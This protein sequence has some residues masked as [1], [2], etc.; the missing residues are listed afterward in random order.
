MAQHLKRGGLGRL[1]REPLV[2]FLVLGAGLFVLYTLINPGAAARRTTQIEVGPD[3]LAWITTTWF[4]QYRRPPSDAELRRLVDDYVHDEILYR[5]ALAMGLDRDDIIVKRRLVQKVGFLTEDMAT[6]RTPTQQDLAQYFAADQERYRLPPRLTFTHIYF[7]TDRRGAAAR[8][9]AE[10]VLATLRHVG[11]PA[12]A[13]ELGDRF[14]LQYDFAERSPDEI[15]IL[16]GG[17][18][19]ESLFA[20]PQVPGWQGPLTSGFGVHLVRVVARAPGR[21]PGLAEVLTAVSQDY[22]LQRRNEAN[23]R[24]YATLRGRY[25][26][27]V[28]SAA[29]RRLASGGNAR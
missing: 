21:M 18:F 16:F 13:P 27:H 15:A 17:M 22:D 7:S 6:Q 8:A 9:D 20:L 24:R 2:H 23:A 11:A 12:R 26:V 5:E 4:Q 25:T 10:R 1:V 29:F 19:A 14:M 3:E 28:D